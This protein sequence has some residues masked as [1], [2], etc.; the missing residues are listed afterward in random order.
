MVMAQGNVGTW[1]DVGNVQ[2]QLITS[3]SYECCF[4]LFSVV[5]LLLPWNTCDLSLLPSSKWDASEYGYGSIV[6]RKMGRWTSQ[7]IIWGTAEGPG[8]HIF[9]GHWERNSPPWMVAGSTSRHSIG[10]GIGLVAAGEAYWPLQGHAGVTAGNPVGPTGVHPAV[11]E[12]RRSGMILG[13]M[14]L[15]VPC[16]K[17]CPFANPFV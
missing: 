16:Y 9:L 7:Q 2:P 12:T 6:I 3:D 15:W 14:V 11:D 8:T 1:G 5:K 13:D 10:M 4:H 17:K